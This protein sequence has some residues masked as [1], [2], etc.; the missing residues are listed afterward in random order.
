MVLFIMTFYWKVV[1]Q[2]ALILFSLCLLLLASCSQANNKPA[3]QIHN[4]N[5]KAEKM[6][7]NKDK[8]WHQVTVNYYDIE[9]GFYGLVSKNGEKLLPRNLA[10]EYQVSGTE[11]KVKGLIIKDMVT[12]QQWGQVFE[13]TDVELIKLGQV[14]AKN[15]Y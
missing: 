14:K 12:I 5:A 2:K 13:I 3:E 4:A 11:L 1:M 8:I 9:G 15:T 7:A 6:T 10:K